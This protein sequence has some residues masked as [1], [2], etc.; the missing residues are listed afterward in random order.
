MNK[1]FIKISMAIIYSLI[2]FSSSLNADISQYKNCGEIK[3]AYINAMNQ[4]LDVAQKIKESLKDNTKDEK[5]KKDLSAIIN[6]LKS[7][8]YSHPTIAG[9][10]KDLTNKDTKH[11]KGIE[12]QLAE[13]DNQFKS[14]GKR[15]DYWK[16]EN[17]FSTNL[18]CSQSSTCTPCREAWGCD[19]GQTRSH[20]AK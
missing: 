15:V 9:F 16:A 14:A 13:L 4:F 7:G 20:C 18:P 11:P 12:G 8:D 17:N 5:F 3:V 1:N 19:L 10:Y 6:T 2:F